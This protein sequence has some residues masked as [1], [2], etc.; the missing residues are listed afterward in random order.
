K[1]ITQWYGINPQWYLPFGLPGHE[2]LD[3]RAL[4][5]TP[6]YAMAKGEVVRVEEVAGSGPY[7]IHVRLQ[8]DFGGDIFKTV[9]AHFMSS[10]LKVGDK[11]EAGQVVGISDN[12][13]NSSGP[14]LHIT[15]KKVGMGSPWMNMGDIINPVPYMPDLF[16]ECAI[17]GYVGLGWRVD[18]GG[19]FRRGPLVADNLIRYIPAGAVVFPTGEVDWD[20]GGDW[21]ELKFDNVVGWFWNPGY[22]LSAK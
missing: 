11:V 2:G 22:K 10:D 5:T 20:D 17:A 13:G 19:N 21:W 12:T 1:I 14:H 7:G 3:M 6:I 8:H 15:L 16:P 9:Y 18:T 4:N